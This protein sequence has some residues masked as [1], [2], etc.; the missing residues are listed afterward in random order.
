MLTAALPR[1]GTAE[2]TPATCILT[3]LPHFPAATVTYRKL[4][5]YLALPCWF[6]PAMRPCLSNWTSPSP[7]AREFLV[8][9][10]RASRKKPTP[11]RGLLMAFDLP[12]GAST[13]AS[14]REHLYRCYYCISVLLIL[15][16]LQ[17]IH[18]ITFITSHFFPLEKRNAARP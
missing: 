4:N 12:P 18:N 9:R 3:T 2:R 16:R 7:D 1:E 5:R 8:G 13:T 17:G 10:F 11:T 15:Q 6:C 14:D